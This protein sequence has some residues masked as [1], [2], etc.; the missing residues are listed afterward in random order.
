MKKLLS[1]LF[2]LSLSLPWLASMLAGEA[3]G[4]PVQAKIDLAYVAIHREQE[5]GTDGWFAL[6]PA[7]QLAVRV[8][9]LVLALDAAGNRAFDRFPSSYYAI[10][11]D[12]AES[13]KLWWL[14]DQEPL[15]T[16]EC[17]GGV[18]IY[19]KE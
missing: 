5:L 9:G 3:P 15:V 12:D 8:A 10:S 2:F 1:T 14:A 11:S 6:A 7:S 16:W 4:C 17:G 19:E 18:I 13:G